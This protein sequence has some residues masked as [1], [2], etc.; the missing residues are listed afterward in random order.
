MHSS[1][2]GLLAAQTQGPDA[3]HDDPV[4]VDAALP[5]LGDAQ[6]GAGIDLSSMEL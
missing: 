2:S 3:E 4:A 5:L 6:G 1:I